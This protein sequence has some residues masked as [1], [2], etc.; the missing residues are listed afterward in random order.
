MRT[1]RTL[2]IAL[3]A[4]A[5]ALAACD[6]G[7]PGSISGDD[8]DDDD[9]APS[10]DASP[11]P[12]APDAADVPGGPDASVEKFS[13][14]VA[15]LEVMRDL[16]GSEDGFG[17][18]LGGLAGADAICQEAASRVGFGSKTW[19]AFLSVTNDGTGS[20]VNAIDRI[21]NGPWYDR[22]GRLIANNKSDLLNTRPLGDAASVNDLPNEYGQPGSSYGDSHD[23]LTGTNTSGQLESSNPVSTCYDWTSAVG[24]G[25]E[26][27]VR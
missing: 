3:S 5:L 22:N 8:D 27:Q 12:G 20:P 23:V 14:F 15:S 9:V 18:D 2:A 1:P 13:F 11:N 7:S 24:P 17:G 19:R 6:V 16:S 10:Y 21:G 26:N 25:S 4:A